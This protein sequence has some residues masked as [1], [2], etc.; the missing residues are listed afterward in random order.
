MVLEQPWSPRVLE[1]QLGQCWEGLP[2]FFWCWE[3]GNALCGAPCLAV[4]GSGAL[5]R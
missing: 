2:S 3:G 4:G 1:E 5:A